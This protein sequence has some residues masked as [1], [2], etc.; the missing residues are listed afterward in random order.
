MDAHCHVFNGRDLP[1]YG[2]LDHTAIQ[3]P[4]LQ[5]IAAPLVLMISDSVE[6]LAKTYTQELEA[7]RH[8]LSD[9]TASPRY[10][11]QPDEFTKFVSFTV[12]RFIE[13]RTSFGGRA[14]L[15]DPQ[16]RRV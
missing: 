3:N 5:K 15:G 14:S 8:I 10:V 4:F 9:P 2:F 1:V 13:H 16:D 7:L 6:S 12:S 11:S